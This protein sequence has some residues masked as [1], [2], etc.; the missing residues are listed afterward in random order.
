M[1]SPRHGIGSADALVRVPV[2]C[3]H[4]V[5]HAEHIKPQRLM[6]LPVTTRPCLT[7]LSHDYVLVPD[8]I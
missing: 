2:F 5:L 6:V 8:H 7:H 4:A 3:D 1:V